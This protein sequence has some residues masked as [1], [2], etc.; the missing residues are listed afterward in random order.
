MVLG[1]NRVVKPIV[2][3]V[4]VLSL[5]VPSS[6]SISSFNHLIS[7]NQTFVQSD[8][9]MV[10]TV[11][12]E[13]H[14][15]YSTIQLPE[16]NSSLNDPGK[17]VLPILTKTYIYPIGTKI[18]GVTASFTNKTEIIIQKPIEKAPYPLPKLSNNQL[19]QS[20]SE[21]TQ[22]IDSTSTEASQIYPEKEFE[23]SI[24]VGLDKGIRVLFVTVHCYPV[25]YQ[26]TTGQLTTAE[27][28]EISIDHEPPTETLITSNDYDTV[29]IAPRKFVL[30]LEPLLVHKNMQGIQTM[31]KTT[32]SI[33]RESL[34]GQYGENGRDQAEQIKYFIKYAIETYGIT[35]VLLVGGHEGQRST[36]HVPVRY[37][38]L[39]DRS[40]WNDTYVT[41]LYFADIYTY[42]ETTSTYEF[43]DWDSNNNG[44]IG[45]WTWIYD[46]EQGW[47]YDLDQKDELDL[48]PDVYLGRLAC[49]DISEVRS[50]VNKIIN[51]ERG[52][53]HN[54][55]FKNIVCA[56]GD[57]VPYSD[58]VCEGEIETGLGSSYL[59]Q[60]GFTSTKL[61]VTNN[62]LTGPSDVVKE[63]RKG[64]GFLYLS[65]HGTPMEWCTHP[66]SDGDTWIDV[67]GFQ[68][69]HIFNR[70]KLPICVVGGCHNSQF[71]VSLMNIPK[72]FLEYGVRYFFWDE[73]IECF[74]KWTWVPECWS[75]NLVSQQH[76]GFIAAIG[77][78]GLGWGVGGEHCV[79]YNEGYLTSHFF[80]VYTILSQQGYDTLGMVHSE[81]INQYID[82]FLPNTD[83][84]DR[85][86][87][88]EWVLL[89]DPSLRIG[90]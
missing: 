21:Q 29:I 47:W 4:I 87:I 64:A 66:V 27:T 56:G 34:N 48:Y 43:D 25:R 52:I 17:P 78:S 90:G 11:T 69:Q 30:S 40:F 5:F 9:I 7:N 2:V 74:P 37:S 1:L 85:K 59:E 22:M 33:Y 23:Y 58:G 88:E 72:G 3:L 14:E 32:E 12:V 86:T 81:T 83:L 6:L 8:S 18:Q 50:V 38:N 15:S 45:E 20:Y 35:Y 62:A 39:Q 44:I 76:D 41:D 60:I 68:M 61:W 63:L 13:E 26:A 10:S 42:N 16:S 57:T 82:R 49:R 36:W 46:P 77:N 84:L 65:G 80:Q 31:I 19:V 54:S 67:Y 73:G 55:W 53:F 79:E 75:W 51:Y 70:N 28:V 89:G 71:D 24:G